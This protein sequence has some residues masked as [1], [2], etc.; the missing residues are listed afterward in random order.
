MPS[1]ADELPSF[2]RELRAAVDAAGGAI[3]FDRFMSLAL[4]GSGGFYSTGGRAGR[5]GDFITSPE[6][7]PLFGAVLARAID[8]WWHELGEPD[9]FTVVEVGAGPGTLARSVLAAEP[10]CRP[11]YVAVEVAEGQRATHPEGVTSLPGLPDGTITGVVI[12]NE[13]LDNLPFRLAVFD[14]VWREAFVLIGR[15]GSPQEMLSIPIDPLPDWLPA[16]AAHGSRVPIQTEA[17]QWVRRAAGS[18]ERGRV[19]AFDYCVARTTELAMRPWREWLRTYRAHERGA[20]YLVDAGMQDITTEVCL[21]QLPPADATRTQAQFL[22]RWGIGELVEEG[23]REWAAAASAPTL[24]AL[25]M[26][27][28][29]R[30]AEALL[31]PQGLGAFTV[32]EWMCEHDQAEHP[33]HR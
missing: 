31:D 24:R 18:L 33:S 28:R 27:S 1:F 14:G 8:G 16:R 10:R 23:R 32:A 3:P 13:L 22:Q 6:V 11:R 25:T 12:A 19:V 26:R 30:E 4:Y 7:G 15:D 5:R 9:D 21:D 29:V 17:A 20:H 2:T